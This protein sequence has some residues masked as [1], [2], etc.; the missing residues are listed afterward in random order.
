MRDVMQLRSSHD[1]QTHLLTHSW[2]KQILSE[3]VD[4]T[5]TVL[6][7]DNAVAAGISAG[8]TVRLENE[9]LYVESIT[10][11]GCVRCV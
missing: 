5:A 11:K 10:G 6:A 2:H 4:D 3:E 9:N 1:D 8:D 7:V